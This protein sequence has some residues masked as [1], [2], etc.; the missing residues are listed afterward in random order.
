[1]KNSP[2]RKNSSSDINQIKIAIPSNNIANDFNSV[3]KAYCQMIDRLR[4]FLLKIISKLTLVKDRSVA[5]T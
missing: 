2:P 5:P 1:M 3:F 4:S